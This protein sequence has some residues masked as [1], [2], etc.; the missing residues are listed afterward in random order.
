MFQQGGEFPS[1]CLG[2][3][4]LSLPVLSCRELCEVCGEVPCGLE[5]AVGVQNESAQMLLRRAKPRDCGPCMKPTI[6]I[7]AC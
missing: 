6:P 3:G 1:R 7:S 4:R 5:R 2:G